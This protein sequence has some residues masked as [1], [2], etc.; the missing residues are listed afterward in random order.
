MT[1]FDIEPRASPPPNSGRS[2]GISQA[3]TLHCSRSWR[4]FGGNQSFAWILLAFQFQFITKTA[5]G[6]RSSL[7]LGCVPVCQSRWFRLMV[8]SLKHFAAVFL[9]VRLCGTAPHFISA[10]TEVAK[11]K[12]VIS[13]S[14]E[15]P[16]MPAQHWIYVKVREFNRYIL[17]T[18]QLI[19]ERRNQYISYPLIGLIGRSAR[20][21]IKRAL[22]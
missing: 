14:P 8:R 16:G 10:I 5:S 18:A 20:P 6:A 3:L 4:V 17:R 7:S 1:A 15:Y 12:D 13:S 21:L 9:R 19:E 11:I 2:I 22:V